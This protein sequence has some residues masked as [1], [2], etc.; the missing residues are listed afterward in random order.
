M[1]CKLYQRTRRAIGWWLAF[2]LSLS[3]TYSRPL[4]LAQ[5]AVE[6]P[7]VFDFLIDVSGSMNDQISLAKQPN[8]TKASKLAEVKNRMDKLC[9]ELP[10]GHRVIVTVFDHQ[11]REV[12]DIVLRSPADRKKL[13][14][15]IGSIT[16][17][18]GS[19]FLWRSVDEELT[20]AS[21]L[22]V[23]SS[24]RARL[25]IYSDGEDMEKNPSFT[26]NSILGKHGPMIQTSLNLD[27][28]T[29]GYDLAPSI[30]IDFEKAGANVVRAISAEQ[31]IP[32]RSAFGVSQSKIEAEQSVLVSDQSTG[33]QIIKQK[34]DY[35]DGTPTQELNLLSGH[36]DEIQH[37]YSRPGQYLIRLSTE[38]SSGQRD[39][40]QRAI[41]VENRA[42]VMPS[43]RV[44]S[45]VPVVEQPIRFFAD[46]IASGLA[47]NWNFSDGAKETGTSVV[48]VPK[49][50]G[51]YSVQLIAKD[52]TG[53]TKS[54]TRNL[55]VP[56]PAFPSLNIVLNRPSVEVG[57]S[58]TVKAEPVITSF[59]YSW[60]TAGGNLASGTSTTLSFD[61]PGTHEIRLNAKDPYGQSGSATTVVKVRPPTPP[62]AFFRLASS[63]IEPGQQLIA[64][65]ESSPTASCFVWRLNGQLVSQNRNL[66]Y[67][68][69]ERGNYKV[70]LIAK[71]NF[72]QTHACAETVEVQQKWVEPVAVIRTE[73]QRGKG[74]LAVRFVNESLG[75]AI[76][77]E[78][79]PGDGSPIQTAQATEDFVHTYEPGN[80]YP[81]ITVHGPK[82]AGFSPVI[83]KGEQITVAKPTPPWV[84]NLL[85]QLPIGIGIAL[86]GIASANALRRRRDRRELMRVCGHVKVRRID[87]PLTVYDFD[88][89]ETQSEAEVSLPDETVLKITNLVDGY[90][91]QGEFVPME[92][93]IEI[94]HPNQETKT[95]G[96]LREDEEAEIGDYALTFSR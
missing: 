16:S 25:I 49:K 22:V 73:L 8:L 84:A 45:K 95:H 71:D 85:W 26:H 55:T 7:P 58:V 19:T 18:E 41:T 12:C 6:A 48:W 11:R 32:L 61:Q 72:G 68:I 9:A 50:P 39:S 87:D 57:E 24:Q 62:K 80:W 93:G 40:S 46:Q 88:L 44:D 34:L 59:E 83:W 15:A 30:K 3:A 56:I 1:C 67:K 27:W 42:W 21:Q 31:L 2:V 74:N 94:E 92:Y 54:Q 64:R 53:E 28:V 76:T 77:C 86:C 33:L 96:R 65:N 29:L 20:R 66:E 70:E 52:E 17:R 38:T 51:K 89:D 90:S 79:D 63:R 60:N 82:E 37:R 91:D 13:S 5:D 81:T 4:C 36:F 78:L 14:Q 23:S 69:P 10:D 75:D 47:L 35:G 43:I